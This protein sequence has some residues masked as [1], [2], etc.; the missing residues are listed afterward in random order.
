MLFS[1]MLMA[2]S[3]ISLKRRRWAQKPLPDLDP[4]VTMQQRLFGVRWYSVWRYRFTRALRPFLKFFT[5][6]QVIG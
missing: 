2:W 4:K 1:K 6:C 5:Q 3:S